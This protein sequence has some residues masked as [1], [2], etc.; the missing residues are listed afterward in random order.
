MMEF[1]DNGLGAWEDNAEFWDE[2][3]GDDSNYFHCEIVRPN[4][5]KLLLIDKDELVLDV[6]CG[7]GNFSQRMAKIGARVVAFDYSKKMIELAIK[8]RFDVLDRVDFR[9]CDATNKTQLLALKQEKPYTKAVANMAIMDISSLMPLFSAV[10]EMLESNGIFVFATHH[11]CFSFENEDYFTNCINKGVAIEG[12]PTLQNYYHRTLSDI[13]NA[14]IDAGF[15][16]DGFFEDSFLGEKTPVIITV[17]L[18]KL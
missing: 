4:V 13:L 6:A 16:I 5:E 18:R 15:V 2:Q 10:F 12:Q 3:M 1:S 11:P 8:R 17:R 9:I 7:N 14:A